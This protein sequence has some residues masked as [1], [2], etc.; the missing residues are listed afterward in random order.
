MKIRMGFVSNSSS[1]SFVVLTTKE[2]HERVLAKMSEQQR[3][4]IE[5]M[6]SK[7]KFLGK[8]MVYLGGLGYDGA[9]DFTE[10][11]DITCDGKFPEQENDDDDETETCPSEIAYKWQEMVNENKEETF[12]WSGDD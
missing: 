12:G 10:N 4:I 8:E 5:Q 2:N 6:I 11:I 7:T 1:S 9:Y 3:G